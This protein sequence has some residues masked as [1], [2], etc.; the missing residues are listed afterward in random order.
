[1]VE[2][3]KEAVAMQLF[4][5]KKYFDK[6][7][8]LDGLDELYKGKVQGKLYRLIYELNKNTRITV[9]TPV[10]DTEQEDVGET[11]SQGSIDAGI[12][13]SSNLS[14]G[15]EDFFS[16]SEF[17]GFYGL[18][19]LQPLLYQDDLFRFCYDRLSA[20]MGNDRLQNLAET[21]LLDYHVDKSKIVIVGSKKARL[22]LEKEFEDN[23]PRL[24]EESV[25][26]VKEVSYLGDQLG[27]SV[28]ESVTMTINKR[29]GIVKKSIYE[30]KHIVEDIRSKVTGGIQTGL[31]LWEACVIPYLLYNSSTWM[32][33]KKSDIERLNKIDRMFYNL[34]LGVQH[35]PSIGMYWDL[36]RLTILNRILKEKLD[37]DQ[38]K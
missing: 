17:E 34:L 33:M 13:S 8:L 21:K 26:I 20:Q 36:G 27:V 2:K 9:R 23:P 14:S 29:L 10:G 5:L 22:N 24:Y 31:I 37:G 15:V 28:A 3:N 4:D 11:I 19:R 25:E 1:M 30:I 16:D 32:E 18:L 38:E 12:V 6:E 35:C 7:F